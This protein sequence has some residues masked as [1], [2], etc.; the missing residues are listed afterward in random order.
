MPHRC[1]W[2]FVNTAPKE[3]V[4]TGM[5]GRGVYAYRCLGGWGVRVVFRWSASLRVVSVVVRS[6]ATTA[7]ICR[8]LSTKHPQIGCVTSITTK[9]RSDHRA[10]E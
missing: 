5:R 9:H 6:I 4:K 10:A 7:R 1:H 2:L 3:Q 8:Q